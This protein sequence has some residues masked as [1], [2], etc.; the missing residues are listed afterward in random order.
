VSAGEPA[1]R[2]WA[3]GGVV[4]RRAGARIEDVTEDDE[5]RGTALEAVGASSD[6]W[7]GELIAEQYE[8]G[9]TRMRLA[10]VVAMGRHGSDD[11]LPVLIQ[12]FEDDD[13]DVRAGAATAAGHLLLEA[14][15]EPLTLLL[16][17]DQ[18]PEVQVAAIRAL[19]E[20][21]GEDA[22]EILKRLLESSEEH[23]VEAAELAI[24]ESQMMAVDFQAEAR[25]Q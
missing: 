7:V 18:E 8:T 10:S 4:Y 25:R 11:W 1:R 14:A 6:E 3:A 16:D 5:V 12:S 23:I 19:G 20:I 22:E 15:I 17:E 24:E 9:S 13:D 21:G 2:I